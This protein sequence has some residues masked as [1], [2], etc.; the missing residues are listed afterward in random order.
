M[1]PP[2][3]AP[4]EVVMKLKAN[5]SRFIHEEF[6]NLGSFGWQDGFRD[7]SREQIRSSGGY[8]IHSEPENS[9]RENEL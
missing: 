9:S 6:G 2:K 5:S 7:F 3:Y 8:R 4:S 1:V